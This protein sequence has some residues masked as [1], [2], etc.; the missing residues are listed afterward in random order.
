MLMVRAFDELIYNVDR[1]LGNLL[2]DAGWRV[3]MIDH[4]RAFKIFDRLGKP[5]RLGT[6]CPR[7]LLPAL[8]RLD[9]A[10]LVDGMK[11][12]LSAGQ[13]RALLARRDAIVQ[14]YEGKVRELGED[15]VLYDLPPR[16]TAASR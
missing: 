10:T 15:A 8:K 13:V 6:R 2:F 14:Y 11:D 4:T 1:N 5:E 12:L 16:L 3:W 7:A 9:E